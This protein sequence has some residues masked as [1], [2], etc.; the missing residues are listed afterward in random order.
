M[1]CAQ[2]PGVEEIGGDT[3]FL[4]DISSCYFIESRTGLI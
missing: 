2:Q 1:S 3:A 4:G